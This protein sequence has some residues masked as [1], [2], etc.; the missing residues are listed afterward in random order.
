MYTKLYHFQEATNDVANVD[1]LE[2]ELAE[3][4]I[5]AP[6]VILAEVCWFNFVQHCWTKIQVNLCFQSIQVPDIPSE[7]P[8]K[9]TLEEEVIP[10]SNPWKMSNLFFSM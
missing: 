6:P 9:E 4:V 5:D 1:D 2:K 3:I 10:I 7:D 8:P